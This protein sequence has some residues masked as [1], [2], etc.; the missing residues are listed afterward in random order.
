MVFDHTANGALTLRRNGQ[1]IAT[2]TKVQTRIASTDVIDAVRMVE[3]NGAGQPVRMDDLYISDRSG[4]ANNDFLGQ[5]RVR[6]LLPNADSQ[7]QRA[8]TPSGSNLP[9]I[10]DATP[11]HD[12]GSARRR[13]PLRRPLTIS[14][15][16]WRPSATA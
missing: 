10:A 6:T 8:P 2:R 12:T 15:Y 11:D 14:G 9:H 13:N 16:R 1:V 4:T 7:A 5:R 3:T